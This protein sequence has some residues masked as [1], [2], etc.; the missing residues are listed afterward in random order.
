MSDNG[1]VVELLREIRDLQKAHFERY[2]EVT[3]SIIERQ[4][5][6][7]GTKGRIEDEARLGIQKVVADT[8]RKSTWLF[9][10]MVGVF[11]AL[12]FAYV[13]ISIAI[14]WLAR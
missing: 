5:E 9:L 14:S 8:R 11:V 10:I 1:E 7:V 4:Q 13:L 3:A 6:A 12:P 2:K